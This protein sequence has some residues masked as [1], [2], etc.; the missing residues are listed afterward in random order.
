[1]RLPSLFLYSLKSSFVADRKMYHIIW[2]N[3]TQSSSSILSLQSI[4]VADRKI[5]Y[6]LWYNE[7]FLPVSLSLSHLK[8]ISINLCCTSQNVP[9]FCGNIE[10]VGLLSAMSIF[11]VADR[12]MYHVLW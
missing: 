1:M 11:L 10:T 3:P 9:I 7:N 2:H 8:S 5:Y 12:K 6:V 4:L